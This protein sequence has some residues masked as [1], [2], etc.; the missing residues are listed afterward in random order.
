MEAI[1]NLL[2]MKALEGYRTYIGLAGLWA[3]SIAEWN[4]FDVPQF[5]ALDPINT[6]MATMIAL[7]I[8]E[9]AKA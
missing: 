4:G 7:G 9:K 5:V 6:F 1:T 3:A 2:K 8:Y